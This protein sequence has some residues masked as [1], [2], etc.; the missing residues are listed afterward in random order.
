MLEK[1]LTV[2]DQEKQL[3]RDLDDLRRRWSDVVLD[4]GRCISKC[5]AAIEEHCKVGS[6]M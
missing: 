5:E 6:P 3:G 2:G 1:S 4:V